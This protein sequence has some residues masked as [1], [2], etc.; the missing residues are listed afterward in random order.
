MDLASSQCFRIKVDR[1]AI[2]LVGSYEFAISQPPTVP[3]RCRNRNLLG[4]AGIAAKT[5]GSG[6]IECLGRFCAPS[7]QV[8]VRGSSS[9]PGNLKN[10][11]KKRFL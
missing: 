3:E 11:N 1:I 10:K 8:R 4:A 7:S 6:G 2:Q 9:Q 5:R